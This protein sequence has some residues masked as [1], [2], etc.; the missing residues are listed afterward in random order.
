[1][2]RDT[3][4]HGWDLGKRRQS[5]AE[6]LVEEASRAQFQAFVLFQMRAPNNQLYHKF[7]R[8]H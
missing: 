6:F 1:M 3:A 5:Q 4:N 2:K 8:E 7:K